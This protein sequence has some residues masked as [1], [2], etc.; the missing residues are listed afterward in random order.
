MDFP[1]N[2]S[3]IMLF[4]IKHFKT[5]KLFEAAKWADRQPQILPTQSLTELSFR[6]GLANIPVKP[7]GSHDVVP[8]IQD[9]LSV[10]QVSGEKEDSE[11]VGIFELELDTGDEE[12]CVMKVSNEQAS[13]LF[14]YLF[15]E[16]MTA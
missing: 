8:H 15:H 5:I 13:A 12:V 10:S 11:R 1:V 2:T 6:R 16:I 7:V 4:S 9:L 3:R 14:L